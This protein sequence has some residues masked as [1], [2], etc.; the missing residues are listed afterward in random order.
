V[1]G[2]GTVLVANPGSD[3]YGSD[4]MMLESVRG[5]VGAGWRVVVTVP[6]DG[7]LVAEVKR[8]GADVVICRTATVRKSALRP[9]GAVRL[10][11]EVLGAVRPAWSLLRRTRPDVLYI[12]TVTAPLWFA[13]A[14]CRGIPVV[15]HVHEAEA[16]VHRWVLRALYAPVLAS[17]RVIINSTFALSVLGGTYRRLAA[18]ATVVA[19]AV[20]G[21]PDGPA[22]ARDDPAPPVRLLYVGRLSERKGPH[23]VIAALTV[24][25]TAGI[26]ARLVLVGDVFPGYEPYYRRLRDD[27]AR[28]DLTGEVEFVGFQPDAWRYRADADIVLVPSVA[29]ESFGNTAVEAALA[30]RPAVVSD[31]AGLREATAGFGATLRV[32]PS[33]PVAVADA[34]REI[35]AD[36]PRYC[37]LAA[38]DGET[39]A[40]R[41][42]PD[43]YG[44]AVEEIIRSAAG[45][46][47]ARRAAGHG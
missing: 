19:N 38:A 12:S 22:D 1:T 25:R 42:R 3:L 29:D 27:V 37:S 15:C 17:T 36:W 24:L 6:G 2:P 31:I 14:R 7:P 20:T 46:R 4:R 5:L 18:R 33:D 45:P 28:S 23:V 41:H 44:R 16:S 47:S 40:L 8:L 26:P 34:V 32:P 13:L 10:L 30:A 11:R 21:P 39:A 9:R 43:R 35:V